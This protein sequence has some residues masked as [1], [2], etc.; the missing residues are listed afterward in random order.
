M[1]KLYDCDVGLT[2]RGVNYEFEHVDSV[3]VDDPTRTRL[4]RGANARNKTG[5][6]YT[7]GAKDAKT[8]NTSVI[9]IPKA[10]HDLLKEVYAS[11]ERVDG[12]AISRANGNSKFW[13]NAILSQEPMQPTLDDSPESMNTPLAFESFDVSDTLKE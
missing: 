7:E 9:G 6:A 11:K 10:L 8:V 2:I 1:I 4:V 13:K 3:T 5:L 12:W